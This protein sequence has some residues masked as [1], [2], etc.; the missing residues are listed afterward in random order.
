LTTSRRL[1]G[2]ELDLPPPGS[3]SAAIAAG[4]TKLGQVAT[5]TSLLRPGMFRTCVALASTS[6]NCRPKPGSDGKRG[7][8]RELEQKLPPLAEDP[9]P[10]ASLRSGTDALS[11]DA[12]DHPD[13]AGPLDEA[14]DEL[15]LQE[16]E[17]RVTPKRVR[18]H[19]IRAIEACD[20]DGRPAGL[21]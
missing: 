5:L 21:T 10:P 14:Q 11:I 15:V 9:P 12:F 17:E 18:N 4:G 7:A 1:G 16:I 2:S 6:S 19:P 3:G 8:L 20:G 13:V